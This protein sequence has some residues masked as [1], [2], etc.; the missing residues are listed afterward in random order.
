LEKR[1]ALWDAI[2]DLIQKRK[3]ANNQGTFDLKG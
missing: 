1:I 2:S 3:S